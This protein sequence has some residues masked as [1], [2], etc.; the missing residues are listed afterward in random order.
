VDDP[1]GLDDRYG[2][3]LE[4]GRGDGVLLARPPGDAGEGA[5]PAVV[6][7]HGGPYG[8][9]SPAFNLGWS[10]WARV[11]SRSRG[12]SSQPAPACPPP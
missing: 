1:D 11:K 8:C 4:L 3:V 9:W 2:L 10:N 6:L 7:V 12:P 5:L